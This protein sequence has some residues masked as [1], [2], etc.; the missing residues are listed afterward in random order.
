MW[1]DDQQGTS[2]V[3]LA[4]LISSLKVVGKNKK[5][6]QIIIIG[7]GVLLKVLILLLPLP[8]PVQE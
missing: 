6:V 7:L 1:H 5:E 2:A 3:V 4:G 8:H